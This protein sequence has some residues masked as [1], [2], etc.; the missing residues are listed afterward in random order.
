MSGVSRIDLIGYMPSVELR[1]SV[2]K[3]FVVYPDLGVELVMAFNH[4]LTAQEM[5][6]N[7]YHGTPFYTAIPVV[8]RNTPYPRPWLVY[9]ELTLLPVIKD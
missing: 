4:L 9:P 3:H 1:L 5:A 8:P 6:I 2:D 7:I